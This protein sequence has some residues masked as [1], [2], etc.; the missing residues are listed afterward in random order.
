[1]PPTRRGSSPRSRA[2]RAPACAVCEANLEEKNKMR[3]VS[4]CRDAL[5][6]RQ[7]VPVVFYLLI[8]S[9]TSPFL[10]Y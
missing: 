6:T 9:E 4:G 1:M 8:D 5:I 2:A 3:G 7:S 10:T